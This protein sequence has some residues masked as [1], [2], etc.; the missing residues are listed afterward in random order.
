MKEL[1]R[2]VSLPP[3]KSMI[4]NLTNYMIARIERTGD[5][6]K[7]SEQVT[8]S[9]VEEFEPDIVIMAIGSILVVLEDHRD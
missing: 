6:I 7:L 8:P 3:Q 1:P 4:E 5:E 9:S 2:L